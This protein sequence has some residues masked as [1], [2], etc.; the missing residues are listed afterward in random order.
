[1]SQGRGVELLLLGLLALLWGS[2]FAFIQVGVQGFPPVTLI[3]LRCAVAAAAL[4]LVLRLRGLSMP[5]DAMAWRDFAIQAALATVTPF[6]LIAWGSQ[7]VP[8]A[9]A[10]VLASTSP[11][12]A[13]LLGFALRRLEQPDWRKGLGVLLGMGGVIG[14]VAHQGLSGGSLPH[15]LAIVFSGLLFAA[16]GYTGLSHFRAKD[17]L[18]PALGAQSVGMLVLLPAGLALERPWQLQPGPEHILALFGLALL[19]TALAS[20]IWFRLLRT[21]GVV[22]TTSQAYLRVPIGAAI[23]VLLLGEAFPPAALAGTV[24]VMAGVWLMTRQ[25]P[26]GG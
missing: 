21:L 17:P 4:W 13:F 5:R 3:G 11:I 18:L 10:V 14:L 12:F 25:R 1:M 19:C 20:V 16:S 26:G 2:S 6:V 9:L 8:S 15:M 22:A 24:L 7:Q 23:G